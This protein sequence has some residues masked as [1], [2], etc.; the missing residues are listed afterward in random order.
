MNTF[1]F[2]HLNLPSNFKWPTEREYSAYFSEGYRQLGFDSEFVRTSMAAPLQSQVNGMI[3]CV[4]SYTQ[5][6]INQVAGDLF[7]DAPAG[8][9]VKV[10]SQVAEL[11]LGLVNGQVVVA[12]Q[13][14]SELAQQV[15]V[16]VAQQI[17]GQLAQAVAGVIPVL[18]Q[19][20]GAV[21][22]FLGPL[23]SNTLSE[24]E[25]KR[26]MEAA[27]KK[28]VAELPD[29]CGNYAQAFRPTATGAGGVTTPADL[30][31][32]VF[33][34][35]QIGAPLPPTLASMYVLMCGAESQGVGY[36]RREWNQVNAKAQKVSGRP[37]IDPA[38]QRRMWALCKAIMFAAK[39]PRAEG[40]IEVYGDG[41]YSSFAALQEIT[42]HQLETKKWDRAYA[43]EVSLLAGNNRI[44]HLVADVGDY[45]TGTV[46]ANCGTWYG[47]EHQLYKSMQQW[48]VQMRDNFCEYGKNP[49][50][51]QICKWRATASAQQ[52]KAL[53]AG[54][55]N[56]ELVL[57]APAVKSLV[58]AAQ[59]AEQKE[60]DGQAIKTAAKVAVGGGAL[61]ALAKYAI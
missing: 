16:Q 23:L 14:A 13:A 15:G 42:R 9:V 2:E 6:G 25:K 31:R 51:T 55:P 45:A 53:S 36:T 21:I 28:L 3:T 10:A 52:L 4:E 27:K 41:G 49:D 59:T 48:R 19:M 37:G 32:G 46:V 33:L 30:F 7:G 56:Y 22:G 17:G 54:K 57:G 26:A 11:S 24:D 18:G 61:W 34:A 5:K 47:I 1:D 20:A 39:E 8:E 50:P 43:K 40:Q 12:A 38:T 44:E 29:R 60:A 35:A 58:H